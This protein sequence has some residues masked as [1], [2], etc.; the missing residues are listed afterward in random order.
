MEST[1]KGCKGVKREQKGKIQLFLK[2]IG[3]VLIL[4]KIQKKVVMTT[5]LKKR[6]RSLEI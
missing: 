1:K 6:S 5:R 4:V 2:T 3:K